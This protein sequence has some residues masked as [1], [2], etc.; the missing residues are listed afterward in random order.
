MSPFQCFLQHCHCVTTGCGSTCLPAHTQWHCKLAITKC[1]R[2]EAGWVAHLRNT[3]QNKAKQKKIC[4]LKKQLEADRM[5]YCFTGTN[6]IQPTCSLFIICSVYESS[7]ISDCLGLWWTDVSRLEWHSTSLLQQMLKP[8][9]AS[10]CSLGNDLTVWGG[11]L[12]PVLLS[13][14]V[15]YDLWIWANCLCPVLLLCYP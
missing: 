5:V 13:S 6:K 8:G 14:P 12:C 3:K 10:C 2:P 9:R 1:H 4:F 11:S 15:T 7:T